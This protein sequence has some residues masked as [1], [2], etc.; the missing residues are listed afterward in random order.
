ME[1]NEVM[2][3]YNC[4]LGKTGMLD[5]RKVE[6]IENTLSV[7]PSGGLWVSRP[8]HPGWEDWCKS[9]A[10]HWLSNESA[11]VTMNPN[12]RI[13][14][15]DSKDSY[16]NVLNQFSYQNTPFS[17]VL[18]YERIA[19]LYD[20]IEFRMDDYPGLYNDIYGL[21]C[22]QFEKALEDYYES[23]TNEQELAE[24]ETGGLDPDEWRQAKDSLIFQFEDTLTETEVSEHE[25]AD[26]EL[27]AID[28]IG[29][30]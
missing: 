4:N 2:V 28:E 14:V 5:A 3:T 18:D 6:P 7:K 19:K 23:K 1:R 20:V 24:E 22:D 9:E 17:R 11:K 27:D 30:D 8:D 29:F 12:A 10:P 25:L 13:L 26:M 16:Q 21:D 15:I